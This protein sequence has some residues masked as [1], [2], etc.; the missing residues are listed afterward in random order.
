MHRAMQLLEFF[1]H[2]R[3]GGGISN[4]GVDFAEERDTD[5]HRLQIAVIDIGGNDGAAARHF[6]A[7]QL[8]GKFFALGDVLHLFSDHAQARVVHLREV[9][10]AAIHRRS[11][12]L[13]PCV[14]HRHKAPVYTNIETAF[15]PNAALLHCVGCTA[16]YEGRLRRRTDQ[17]AAAVATTAPS[18]AS[19]FAGSITGG[20][21]VV[22]MQTSACGFAASKCGKVSRNAGASEA[23]ASVSGVT[24]RTALPKR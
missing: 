3:C 16:T 13:D 11:A 10:H 8:R 12:L 4:V 2:I 22:S 20:W 5:A 14:P 18:N 1:V 21:H 7:H 17:G 6:I 15:R 9:T 23:A 19:S 24:R